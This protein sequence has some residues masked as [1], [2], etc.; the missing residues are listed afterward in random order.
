MGAFYELYLGQIYNQIAWTG[1]ISSHKGYSV[2][3]RNNPIQFFT[4]LEMCA[5]S[6]STFFTP[7][8]EIDIGLYKMWIVLALPIEII[9]MRCISQLH[10]NWKW[11]KTR[12]L[13]FHDAIGI[14]FFFHIGTYVTRSKGV[15]VWHK[16]WTDYFFANLDGSEPITPKSPPFVGGTEEAF[17]SFWC[18]EK[19][20]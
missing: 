16:K 2:W 1:P 7:N 3:D 17:G 11:L 13:Q 20:T 9:F 18:P 5:S 15:F 4:L 6:F 8:D 12:T 19:N 14:S 10:R